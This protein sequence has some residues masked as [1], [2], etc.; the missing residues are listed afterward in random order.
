MQVTTL[1]K[2]LPLSLSPYQA[3]Y[4]LTGGNSTHTA[5]LE[6]AEAGTHHNPKSLLMISAAARVSARNSEITIEALNDN[7][8][9]LLA[10][11]EL[12]TIAADFDI[13]RQQKSIALT[14][15]SI[16]TSIEE[17][18]RLKSVSSLTIL[19][20]LARQCE[21]ENR[22][23]NQSTNLI[24]ACSFDLVDQ[25]ESLPVVEKLTDDFCFYVADQLLIQSLDNQSAKLICKG[26]G[27]NAK[28][29]IRLG[30]ALEQ[31]QHRLVEQISDNKHNFKF[32][33]LVSAKS[34]QDSELVTVSLSDQEFAK[35]VEKAKQR[36]IDGDAFQVVLSRNYQVACEDPF[37]AYG[38]L[39]Q[40][41]PS[42]YMFY[43]QFEQGTLLGASPESALKVDANQEISLYPIAGT[44]KRA[45]TAKGID[46]EE[47]S[48]IEYEL[49][50]DEK[51]VAE[52]M[53]LVDLARNDIARIA[54]SGTR[55]V[56]QLKAVVKYSHVMHLVSE[57]K[58]Q[59]SRDFDMFDAYR[60]CA[61]MGTLTGAPKIKANEIIRQLEQSARGYYGGAVCVFNA[62]QEFDSAIVIRSAYVC[63]DVA[64]ISA[65]A[66]I[67]YDS[68]PKK[69]CAE[70]YHKALPVINACIPM[71]SKQKEVA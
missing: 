65:G 17:L 12:E 49:V 45:F 19:K 22:E 6:T 40:S 61:N 68:C 50:S 63:N 31:M 44:R 7:G 66:G 14:L 54:K 53:M 46:S 1:S 70:T 15:K 20:F 35:K 48:R 39:R 27:S 13:N 25:F 5:L 2:K 4:R 36:I 29:K 21:A 28:N 11:L 69:E 37:L 9:S 43:I 38:K 55:K 57:V 47:D 30:V 41:N 3:F 51:E 33:N 24:G 18:E 26:F 71:E 8:E 60:A 56:T 52:H 34:D 62:N 67:V 23:D 32:D 16:T 42:P 58:A 10:D 59:L 64:T